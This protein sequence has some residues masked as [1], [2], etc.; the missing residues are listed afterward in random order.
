M[1]KAIEHENYT[2]ESRR[3]E[4]DIA[5][6]QV[7]ENI[8]FNE[9]VQPIKFSANR[10]PEQATVQLTGWGLTDVSVYSIFINN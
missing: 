1:K 4:N 7:V 3:I 5:V 6:V 2:R 8:R 10:V 9:R